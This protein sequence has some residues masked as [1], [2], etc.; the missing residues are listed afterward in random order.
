MF[1]LS[2]HY[3]NYS[4][5]GLSIIDMLVMHLKIEHD[6]YLWWQSRSHTR[7]VFHLFAKTLPGHCPVDANTHVACRSDYKSEF[8]RLHC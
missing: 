2:M 3:L 5:L 4:K 1:I 6:M 7:K 8:Q